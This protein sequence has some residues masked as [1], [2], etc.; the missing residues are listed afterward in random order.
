MEV[1]HEQPLSIKPLDLDS[2]H[3][4]LNY[5]IFQGR[6][7]GNMRLAYDTM[8][9]YI[10]HCYKTADPSYAWGGYKGTWDQ[11]VNTPAGRDSIFDFILYGLG[12]R[13][14]DGWFCLGV[15]LLQVGLGQPNGIPDYRASRALDRF[16]M[17]NPRCRWNYDADSTDYSMLLRAQWNYWSDTSHAPELFD[18]TIPTLHE[19]GLDTLL[20]ISAKAGV[21]YE[22]LGPQIILDARLVG[23]PTEGGGM[24]WLSIGREAYLHIGVY[25]VLGQQVEHA[26]YDGV[27]EQGAREVPLGMDHATPGTYYIRLTTANNEVRTIKL[28]KS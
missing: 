4:A 2:C 18:S 12:L 26:G 20:A 8:Q 9:W 10:R 3:I 15:P 1:K 25:D 14:D 28:V 27:F 5:A 21:Y 17:D 7:F 19:I 16:L 11:V 23:N 13:S 22:K 24:L 6:N